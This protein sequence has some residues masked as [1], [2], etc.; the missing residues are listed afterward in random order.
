ML[1]GFRFLF[2][3]IVLSLS[4]LV[5]G[6][7]AAA[8]LRA[9][10]EEFASNPAWR[11]APEVKFAQPA[12]ATQPALA[13]LR[14]DVPAP[15]KAR[16][17]AAEPASTAPIATPNREP[18]L[19]AE[20]V[21]ADTATPE[22]A[23]AENPA[24]RAIAPASPEVSAATEENKIAASETSA[25]Q[26]APVAPQPERADTQLASATDIAATKIATL[27]GPPVDVETAPPEKVGDARPDQTKPDQAASEKRT[28]ARRAARHRKSAAARAR[29]AAQQAQLQANPFAPPSAAPLPAAPPVR[30]AKRPPS[31]PS[32]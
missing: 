23:V 22:I 14:V 32:T 5:F 30:R 10:H 26:A 21:K 4:L 13:M 12:E 19:Q 6:L 16:E 27:G 3:A 1:P 29:Q 17:D 18:S 7:G 8:L 24:A 9:A 15:E 25:R 20:T 2:A 31:P 11:T 28:Q